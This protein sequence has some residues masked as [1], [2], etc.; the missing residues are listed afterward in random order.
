MCQKQRSE[1]LKNF[2][3]TSLRNHVN[4]NSLSIAIKK[5]QFYDKALIDL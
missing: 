4:Q 3:E 5:T 1:L 2:I